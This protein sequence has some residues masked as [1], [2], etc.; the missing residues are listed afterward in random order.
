MKL[1]Y[2][3]YL[4]ISLI[5]IF[6]Y[7]CNNNSSKS[8]PGPIDPVPFTSV[9]IT[10]QFW[11]PR[12]QRNHE[13]TIPISISQ[14]IE[15]GRVKNFKI[16]GGIE[17]GEFCSQ[18]PFDDSDIFKIIEGASYSLQTFPD[19]SL[20]ATIDSLIYFIQIAQEEDGYLYTYRSI[21][22]DDSHPWVGKRWEKTHL[23][24]HE[25][26]NLGHMYE[27][28]VA[29]FQATGKRSL[30]DI[31]LKSANLVNEEFGWDKLENYPG[32]Q[33]IEIGLVK[34][35]RLT[36][37]Q[38]YLDLAKFFLDIRQGGERYSQSHKPVVEQSE[39][40]G[41]AV[42]AGYMYSGMADVATLT[43]NK[44]YQNAIS[45]IWEDI[46]YKKLYI[47]GGIGASGGNEGFA[48]PYNLPNLSAYCETCSSIANV[49]WNHRMF[50]NDGNAKYID[51]L[52]RTLYNALL[53]GVALSGDRFFYPNRL[54]SYGH[55]ERKE[56]F[57]CACCPSNI[58][59]FIP[60]VPAY[61]YGKK[62]DEL[63]VNLYVDNTAKIKLSD[64]LVEII[65][66]TKY[67][68]EGKV[69]IT[70]NPEEKQAFALFLR[71][72]G[73]AQNEVIASDLYHFSEISEEKIQLSLNGKRIKPKMENG[74]VEIHRNWK[75]GDELELLLP[76]PIR[77]VISNEAVIENKD[78]IA[79]QR[80]PLVFCVEGI[81]NENGK[82]LNLIAD[83]ETPTETNF[84]KD[85]LNGTQVIRIMAAG[86]SY[87]LKKEIKVS[88]EEERLL[89]PYHLWANR[90]P[91][92]MMVW[93][94][95]NKDV[96]HPTPAPTLA[97]RS[98]V[99][100]SHPTENMDCI[101]DQMLVANSNDHSIPYYH[102]WPRNDQME[103]LQYDFEKPETVT[104]AK[105]Y[106]FDDRPDGGC[107]I[108]DSWEI[109][110]QNGSEWM[111]VKSKSPYA[112]SRNEWNE[113]E[114]EPITTTS[115]KLQVQLS[116]EFSSGLYEWEVW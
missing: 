56:W 30:L 32:H 44:E 94:P 42:R 110:Y 21:M 86:S 55:D 60:S 16:A 108:P 40:V 33:E 27:A 15:T 112:V 113:M 37:E 9:K 23:L 83:I 50:L 34:I 72:P 103:W 10:D 75:K 96:S 54:E 46:V 98:T 18:Y 6:G 53:S 97:Y 2:S 115:L 25:L 7:A 109:L 87:N 70:L 111:P 39:A 43:N 38:K 19:P 13:V 47:T 68:W 78:K 45:K 12:I 66:S 104:H 76:M 29:H 14:S 24:S 26:Y 28:A 85:L 61:V 73:W 36:G 71:I 59:R 95:I 22:G 89:I 20:E 52:E 77:K 51:V 58:C 8:P 57:G 84:K 93:F 81:D 116:K 107:R 49:F 100:G 106:W 114:F 80:G 17:S 101:K 41:H 35:Y 102:W 3:K 62:A 74:Y 90:G 67:P 63:Y 64:G 99:S 88:E 5:L 79:Y 11:A 1:A 69:N 82:V 65:Q 4:V 92:E 91:S 31:A 105:I 48:E